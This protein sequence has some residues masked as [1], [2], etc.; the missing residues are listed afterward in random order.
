MPKALGT[1]VILFAAGVFMVSY[2][3]TYQQPV[4]LQGHIKAAV[5]I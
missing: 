5:Y 2:R 4:E 3:M 1:N